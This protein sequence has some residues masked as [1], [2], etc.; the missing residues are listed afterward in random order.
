MALFSKGVGGVLAGLG[1][2][3][4]PGGNAPSKD[5]KRVVASFVR[6]ESGRGGC[7]GKK[8]ARKCDIV[9]NGRELQVGDYTLA[10]RPSSASSYVSVCVPDRAEMLTL[11]SGKSVEAQKSKDMRAAGGAL[12]RALG[13][14]LGV[15][16][17]KAGIRRL[18]GSHGKRAAEVPGQCMVVKLNKAQANLAARSME[19]EGRALMLSK[20]RYP[21]AK[22]YGAAREQALAEKRMMALDSARSKRKTAA[23]KLAKSRKDA[24]KR[25]KKSGRKGW[26]SAA[27]EKA[28]KKRFKK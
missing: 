13:T 11:K 8:G 24:A 23:Q 19:A 14:G 17:D 7:K 15:R 21:T 12:L 6:G 27:A 25:F 10:K 2:L 20:G 1:R 3:T 28:A 5:A 26:V 9:S 18:V 16:T 4:A 22:Q